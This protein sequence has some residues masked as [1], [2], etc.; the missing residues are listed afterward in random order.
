MSY[1]KVITNREYNPVEKNDA[2][3]CPVGRDENG[4]L[5]AEIA[6]DELAAMEKKID[7]KITNPVVST[8][9]KV[10][11]I[12]PESMPI[13]KDFDM[14]TWLAALEY[15]DMQALLASADV[16]GTDTPFILAMNYNLLGS[17]GYSGMIVAMLKGEDLEFLYIS[18]DASAEILGMLGVTQP[19]WGVDT[20]VFDTSVVGKTVTYVAEGQEFLG[21][22]SYGEP[23]Q[24][25]TKTADGEV[26]ADAPSIPTKVSELE[27]DKSYTTIAEVEAKGYL[28]ED[29]SAPINSV[30]TKTE[31]GVEWKEVEGGGDVAVVS[32]PLNQA[33]M[34]LSDEQYDILFNT[35]N[36]LFNIIIDGGALMTLSRKGETVYQDT[37]VVIY[38]GEIVVPSE[39]LQIFVF[40]GNFEGTK[41][42]IPV[43]L[44]SFA[45]GWTDNTFT[46]SNDFTGG[47]KKNGV[48]VATLGDN[49][50]TGTNI[51]NKMV[52]SPN[53][54]SIGGNNP[55]KWTGYYPVTLKANVT[56]MTGAVDL[57]LPQKS[58][59]VAIA[60]DVPNIYRHDIKITW[61]NG[62]IQTA[63]I[64]VNIYV[65]IYNNKSSAYSSASAALQDVVAKGKEAMCSGLVTT[66][67]NT[68]STGA[69]PLFLIKRSTSD[70]YSVSYSADNITSSTQ[71]IIVGN[72][73]ITDNLT[74]V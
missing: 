36:A 65:T 3:K 55:V 7:K 41:G 9:L 2:M 37:Q 10:G 74:E 8:A 23:G 20:A 26:W 63:L 44:G 70:E 13:N 73:T 35:N 47:L 38:S 57:T 24:I 58:G 17:P 69:Y 14:D 50:F 71:V 61:T 28:T 19:G 11:D 12:I 30:P 4:Q 16:D 15:T 5:F 25:L 56:G 29:T 42:A 18:A 40:V 53:G 48:D 32:V 59:T 21:S 33:G 54:Y 27:N 64:A 45:A 49:T 67:A 34:F 39:S 1:L 31:N 51:F 52:S 66:A 43:G 62:T 72:A 6:L 46:G 22:V 68:Q 60:E